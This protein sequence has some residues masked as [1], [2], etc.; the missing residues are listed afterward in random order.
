VRRRGHVAPAEPSGYSRRSWLARTLSAPA[1]AAAAAAWPAHAASRVGTNAT[2]PALGDEDP[3]ASLPWEAMRREHLGDGPLR[4]DAGVQVQVPPFAEDPRN[5]PL[6]FSVPGPHQGRNPGGRVVERVVDRVVVLVDR[7]PIRRVL[8]FEPIAVLPSLA[9]SFRLEQASPV[10]VAVR[11]RDGRWRVGGT[12]VESAGGGC[13]VS[14]TTRADGSW[15]RTLGHVGAR[16]FP[17]SP[18]PAAAA[19]LRLR[20]MHPMDTGLV[21]G[22]PAFFLQRLELQE[23]GGRV[24]MRLSIGEPVSENPVFSIDLAERPR[25]PL[26][27]LGQDNN[28]NRIDQWIGAGTTEPP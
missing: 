1:A 18:D 14:G 17:V 22:I 11:G 6:R 15:P 12:W 5:V 19:R 9:F 2:A 16:L 26:R 4:F 25:S 24:L 27:L 21:D 10:R 28:G 3:F 8:S 7:N 20:V 23:A 13:T